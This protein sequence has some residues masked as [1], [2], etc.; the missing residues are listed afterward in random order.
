[1]FVPFDLYRRQTERAPVDRYQMICDDGSDDRIAPGA[2]DR[3]R[4][5]REDRVS[6]RVSSRSFRV[7]RL[8]DQKLH[9][10]Y[11]RM[12]YVFGLAWMIF[13]G[14]FDWQPA[15]A[16]SPPS[17]PEARERCQAVWRK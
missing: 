3:V 5:F 13:D 8:Q 1:M 4:I 16:R 10:V 2:G 12:Q 6:R 14:W 17:S 7:E 15:P 11:V 9:E